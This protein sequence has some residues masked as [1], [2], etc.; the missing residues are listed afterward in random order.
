MTGLMRHEGPRSL[1]DGWQSPHRVPVQVV[2]PQNFDRQ[3]KEAGSGGCDG[4]HKKGDRC[5]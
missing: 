5:G 3:P 4:H 1:V 2:D